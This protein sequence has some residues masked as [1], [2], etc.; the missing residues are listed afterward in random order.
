MTKFDFRKITL[1][2]TAAFLLKIFISFDHFCPFLKVCISET[3][4][5]YCYL[6][7]T[8]IVYDRTT[9]TIFSFSGGFQLALLCL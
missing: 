2:A 8:P 6:I 1:D 5:Q 9:G 3:L 4:K 7:G